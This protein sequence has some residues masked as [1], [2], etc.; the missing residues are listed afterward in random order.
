MRETGVINLSSVADLI[1]L[2]MR[3]KGKRKLI[4]SNYQK[5]SEFLIT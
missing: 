5:I 4:S 1:E 3:L 2:V